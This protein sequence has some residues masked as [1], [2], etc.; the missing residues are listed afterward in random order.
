MTHKWAAQLL[1]VL[2]SIAVVSGARD[3]ATAETTTGDA[4]TLPWDEKW[5]L[6][7]EQAKKEGEVVMSMWRGSDRWNKYIDEWVTPR[8]Q[9]QFGVKVKVVANLDKEFRTKVLAEKQAGVKSGSLD[10]HWI[11]GSTFRD[12]KQQG[13]L[14]GPFCYYLPSF[15]AY[16]AQAFS[17]E[18]VIDAGT[19][20]DGYE[21][22]WGRSSAVITYNSAK[23]PNSPKT[24]AEMKA[25][26]MANPGRFTY[27][28]IPDFNGSMF[29]RTVV[30]H[31]TGG[32][33]QYMKGYDENLMRGKLPQAWSWFKDVTP[34]LWRAGKTYPD[35]FAKMQDLFASGEIDM[36]MSYGPGAATNA[37]LTGKFPPTTRTAVLQDGMVGN[38]HFLSIMANAP[39]KAAAMVLINFLES[40]EAQLAKL[41]PKG[42]GDFPGI[43]MTRVPPETQ[44]QVKKLDLGPATLA[45]AVIAASVI[46][47]IPGPYWELIEKEWQKNVL[48]KQ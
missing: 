7:V 4:F 16:G 47:E 3:Q 12:M 37:V 5:K 42:V 39:H 25:W 33:Q 38:A 6:I 40:P 24:L 17:A 30:V 9:Q 15:R 23:V 26:I 2:M 1:L 32:Y 36:Y 10:L 18:I 8:M 35:S 22:P 46:P 14:W 13:V 19:P 31:T 34:K 43:D 11:N 45:P 27:P 41:D 28:A 21:C 29:V 20:V 44:E 48:Q